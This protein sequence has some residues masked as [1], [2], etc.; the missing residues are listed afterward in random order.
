MKKLLLG[1][2]VTA[3]VVLAGC[4]AKMVRQD[5]LYAWKGMPVEALDTHALFSTLPVKKTVMDSGI[6]LRTYENTKQ[7]NACGASPLGGVGVLNC[8]RETRACTTEFY[9]RDQ[10][11]IEALARGQCYTDSATR[12][13]AKYLRR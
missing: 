6:E 3:A 2:V 11:V 4:A 8:R 12:P 13:A 7:S 10:K 9:L 1:V 5:D